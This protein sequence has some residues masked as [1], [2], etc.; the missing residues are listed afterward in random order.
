MADVITRFKLET[1]QYD[2]KL[3]DASKGLAEYTRQATQAGNEFGKFTQKNIE[4]ARALGSITPSANNAKD[5][6]KELVGAF[7]DAARAYNALTKEQQQS[8]FGKAMAES[9]GQLS[10]QLKEAKKELYEM[11]D[12]VKNAGGG[13]LFSG[14]GDKMSGALQVFGGNMLTKAAGAVANVGSEMVDMVQ[15]GVELAKQGE[16]IRIAFERLGRGDI[17]QGLRESTHGT[18]TDLELMKAAVKFN[19][20]KLPL[21]ELGTMLAFAQQKAKDTG[22]SVDYM[23]DS[24]VTGLGRKSLMILDNLGLSAN[25]V[26]EKMAETGDMTKAVGAIIREQM[27]KAGD[28]VETAADRAAQAHVSLQNKMEELGRKFAPVEEA[29]SQ[30]WTSMKIGILDIIGG[31]LATLLNQLTEAGRL[32]N[33]L[34]NMNGAPG[35]GNT[36]VDKQ[37]KKLNVIKK[38]GGSDYIFNSTLNGMM[39]DYNRQ[40]AALDAK[41]KETKKLSPDQQA[42]KFVRDEVQK[43]SEQMKALGMM[44]DQLAAGAKELSKP[45]DVKI[46]T[47]GAEQN[48]ESLKVKLIELEAQRKK[49]IAAGDTDLSKNLAKQINQ[50]K[51]DIKGLGGT[52]TT[53]TTHKATPQETASNKVK[54][55][56][57]TYAE[58]LL[59]NSIRLEAG[60][61]TTLEY[62]KR[63]LS[64]QE[65]LFDAYNDAYATYQDPAY[66][67]ASMEAADKIRALAGEVKAETDAQEA[68]KKSARELEA[69]QKKLADAQQKL[70]DARAT[71]SATAVYKA[72]QEVDKRQKV[73]E[74]VQYVADVKAGKMPTLPE[75]MKAEM[76]VTANTDEAVRALQA[77]QGVMI[78][79]KSFDISTD[80]ADAMA[81]VSEIDGVTIGPKTFT[82]T[83]D[84]EDVLAKLREILDKLSEIQGVDIDTKTFT[85]S[86]DNE[87]ALAKVREIQDLK[88]DPKTVKIV[89]DV[90][91]TG[92]KSSFA[93]LVETV[94][95]EIK[96]DQMKVDE[97][98]LHT[99]LQTALQNGLDHLTPDYAGLQERIAKGIDIPDSTWIELQ[100]EINE[101]LKELGKEPIKINF[102][103][104]GVEKV[105][106]SVKALQA[107]TKTTAQVVGTIGQA[108]NAI[109]DPAAKVAA[110]VAQAIA[111][112]AAAYADTML[113]DEPSKSNIYAFIAAAAAATVSMVSTIA[114]IHQ[115]T[116]YA[117][118]GVIKAANGAAIPGTFTVPGTTYSNDQIP[119]MLNAGETVLTRAQAGNIASQLQGAGGSINLNGVLTGE[120]IFLSA[121]RYARRSGRG[122]LVTFHR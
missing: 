106:D 108:F 103:T 76:V 115:A 12:A 97:T 5:K 45:V 77:I 44:R 32:K 113:K 91:E 93:N 14:L 66:K 1:T 99:L 28:Y 22:Q 58:T 90:S 13:G 8:D 55:A 83:A 118:G 111:N 82:V 33:M 24:I 81:K 105:S 11:G 98:T 68:A 62:K 110:V 121:D 49:A 116:G 122:E 85:I 27:S 72:Q 47:K 10:Q 71:G 63:E 95:A 119:A 94:Q 3:R 67:K 112:V 25:E 26:K 16:G 38:G 70:A 53:T 18:V 92:E 117:R 88:I 69:A 78:H 29:S 9:L 7:N 48:V 34:N 57:R 86:T 61:D 31:P 74:Q 109:E 64:A 54:E 60:M 80:D 75:N 79:P 30:L 114:S 20:F 107:T 52:T 41:I 87:E 120:N 56:E 40:I 35:S 19:D 89:Q 15:Q 59:K 39:E 21:D 104:G 17:L 2:S 4:A 102:E 23:V 73:V 6:V 100:N 101:K 46:E 36:K 50:V 96:F 43:M 51:S 65:R 42:S 84:D 37:L